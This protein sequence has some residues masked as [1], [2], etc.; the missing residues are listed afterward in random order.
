MD[1]AMVLVLAAAGV[2]QEQLQLQFAVAPNIEWLVPG[3]AGGRCCIT[4]DL[5]GRDY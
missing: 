4:K 1:E 3:V 5:Q 2:L